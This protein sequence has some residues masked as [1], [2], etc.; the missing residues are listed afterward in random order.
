MG[1]YCLHDKKNEMT[2]VKDCKYILYQNKDLGP[3]TNEITF[4][5]EPDVKYCPHKMSGDFI[6][7]PLSDDIDMLG[8]DKIIIARFTKIANHDNLEVWIN[9]KY[10]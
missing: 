5:Q 7:D 1:F 4:I 8:Q 3:F 6:A 9:E 2:S 10:K